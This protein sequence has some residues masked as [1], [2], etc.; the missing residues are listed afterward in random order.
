MAVILKNENVLE[1]VEVL[2][3]SPLYAIRSE[4]HKKQ[5]NSD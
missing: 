4:P 5:I 1:I 3:L 2:V